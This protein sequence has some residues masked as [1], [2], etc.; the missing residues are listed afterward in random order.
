MY[1]M[2][3]RRRITTHTGGS[4]FAGLGRISTTSRQYGQGAVKPAVFAFARLIPIASAAPLGLWRKGVQILEDEAPKAA[5]DPN[6][7][8]YLGVAILL[9][10]LGGVFAGLTIAL[11]GQDETYLQVIA[12]SG[13]GSERKAAASVLNLL[14]KG[15]HWVLVT[16]LLSNVITNETLP[17][18]L[19]R[20]LG[21][22]WPAVLSS[23]VL[24]V[25]FGEV[26]PQ[27]ICVR[28]GLSI[29]AYMAPAVLVL[30]YITF[31]V[32]WPTAKLLDWLLGE[33]HGI[34]YKKAGLKTLV[35]MHKT[36]GTTPGERLMEDE[37]TIVSLWQSNKLFLSS[38]SGI[39]LY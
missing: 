28:Y 38:P 17:I 7:W 35:Q 4:R 2:S 23:T 10:L 12:T 3:G 20:S 8:V 27:S 1:S 25:I 19:D 29:G 37:V 9:V 34:M 36:L 30:M 15:K 26:A 6:L 31:P 18:V 14:K 39:L 22:G 5:D 32:A 16:L 24:I 21:G 11:M 33:E 13:E